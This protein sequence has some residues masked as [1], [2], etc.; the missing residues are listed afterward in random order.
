MFLHCLGQIS[1]R[2]N[3]IYLR[4]LQYFRFGFC[5]LTIVQT[6]FCGDISTPLVAWITCWSDRTIT[7][8]SD[9]C[10][11]PLLGL[12]LMLQTAQTID[13][14]QQFRNNAICVMI[15]QSLDYWKCLNNHQIKGLN[16]GTIIH[17]FRS[18]EPLIASITIQS[19]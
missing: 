4:F 9:L 1:A 17:L 3:C 5:D 12:R 15:G 13:S 16:R 8:N 18:S 7:Q 11:S 10:Y 14:D 6:Q 2:N 19:Y